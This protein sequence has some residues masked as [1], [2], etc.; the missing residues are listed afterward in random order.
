MYTFLLKAA[1]SPENKMD[2]GK[3]I[4]YNAEPSP[5]YQAWESTGKTLIRI[6]LSRS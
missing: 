5:P 6:E 3:F 2:L 1:R 4:S